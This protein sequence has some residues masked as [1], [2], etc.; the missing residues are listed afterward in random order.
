MRLLLS[1]F[2]VALIALPAYAQT[3]S[4]KPPHTRLTMEQRFEKAN[5]S[6]DGHLTLDQ[7]KAS[8]KTIARHFS[9]IDHD[10]RGYVTLDDVRSYYKT[11]RA[12]HRQSAATRH[13]PNG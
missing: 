11:Q 10:K 1:L 6:N 13:E 4:D 5:V 2:A 8:Y 7:A 3:A 9:A 12:L